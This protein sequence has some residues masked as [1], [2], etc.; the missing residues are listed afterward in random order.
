MKITPH[1]AE[2]TAS[3]AENTCAYP[4]YT[5]ATPNPQEHSTADTVFADTGVYYTAPDSTKD[6]SRD[7]TRNNIP[8][9]VIGEL[10]TTLSV[11]ANRLVRHNTGT[12]NPEDVTMSALERLMF[13]PS[14]GRVYDEGGNLTGYAHRTLFTT[15]LTIYRQDT[16]RYA[17][18]Y[19]DMQLFDA[20][21]DQPGDQ[22]EITELQEVLIEALRESSRTSEDA[23]RSQLEAVWMRHVEGHSS[24][25][26]ARIQGTSH[27]AAKSRTHSAIK[28]LRGSKVL[29]EYVRLDNAIAS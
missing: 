13:S 22:T 1:G 9:E 12:V 4:I 28:K 14:A 6:V 3:F 17:D 25:D 8:D 16:A 10:Y 23:A 27:Q 24:A 5:E 7:H 20:P 19:E 29:R 26:I 2:T 21:A 15:F 18:P 11:R